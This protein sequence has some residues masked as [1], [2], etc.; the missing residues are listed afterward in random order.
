M[1]NK[2]VQFVLLTKAQ[3]DALTT[4]ESRTLYFLSDTQELYRG[5][6]SFSNAVIFYNSAAATPEKLPD[7][8]ALG[9]LYVDTATGK[10]DSYD[11]TA[12]HNVVPVVSDVV[13]ENQTTGEGADA[14]T[15]FVPTAQPVSGKAVKAYVDDIASNTLAA[16]VTDVSYDESTKSLNVTKNGTATPVQLTK[17]AASLSY[18]GS[19]GALSIVDAA[20]NTISTVNIPLDNFVKSGSYN[21]T[22]Q[23][24]D[25]A[26]QNGTTVSIP[27]KDL[28]NLY[29]EL[30]SSSV[31]ITIGT[32]ADGKNTIKADVKISA[33]AG[34][35]L[36]VKDDGLYVPPTTSKMNKVGTGHDDEVLIAGA[37]GDAA[38]SG[39]KVGGA[40]LDADE[41]KRTTLLATEAAVQAAKTDV[42]TTAETTYVKVA[43]VITSADDIDVENPSAEKVISEAALVEAMSWQEL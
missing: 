6:V 29:N 34:N 12:W 22:T 23:T 43:N 9:K 41:T 28:V 16:A 36:E 10:A 32:D 20:G 11:G 40:T 19:T 31:D 27:A 42:E 35:A 2:M 37:D 38:A 24:L 25:I 39:Y 21:A 14:V 1:A 7:V 13:G 3:Y 26:M 18:D 17:I 4:K 33:E 5:E 15:T 8:G 30:D